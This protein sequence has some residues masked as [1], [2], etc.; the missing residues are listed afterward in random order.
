MLLS[1]IDY[2]SVNLIRMPRRVFARRFLFQ[3]AAKLACAWKEFNYYQ[4]CIFNSVHHRKCPLFGTYIFHHNVHWRIARSRRFLTDGTIEQHAAQLTWSTQLYLRQNMIYF[5]HN[6]F[7]STSENLT[8]WIQCTIGVRSLYMLSMFCNFY[9]IP[10]SF[11][12]CSIYDI[13]ARKFGP[14]VPIF[15][16]AIKFSVFA[17]SCL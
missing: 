10:R 1:C 17:V 16:T 9:S 15:A 14:A 7:Q 11:W 5:Y 12:S 2:F 3:T 8:E 4:W 13:R 6:H